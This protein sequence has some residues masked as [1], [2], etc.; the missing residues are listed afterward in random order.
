MGVGILGKFSCSNRG[1]FR[2]KFRS[3]CEL[4]VVLSEVVDMGE[5]LRVRG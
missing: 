2:K 1:V 5:L 4:C 3:F